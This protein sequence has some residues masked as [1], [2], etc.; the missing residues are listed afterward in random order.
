M[1]SGNF[2]PS[3]SLHRGQNY[4]DISLTISFDNNHIPAFSLIIYVSLS[5]WQGPCLIHLACSWRMELD[6]IGLERT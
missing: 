4:E 6:R 5:Q 2:F 3:A 1:T